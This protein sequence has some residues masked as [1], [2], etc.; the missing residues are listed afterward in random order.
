[1]E[2]V[3][4]ARRRPQVWRDAEGKE[5]RTFTIITTEPNEVL[6]P[7]HNRM[8]VI[9]SPQDEAMRLDPETQPKHLVNVL[10]P[11]SAEEMEAYEVSKAVNDVR[12]NTPQCIKPVDS[13]KSPSLF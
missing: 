4:L 12:N 11:Y 5:V 13:P 9:L 8:P 7:T 3:Q 2:G 6:Q 10:K 1:M